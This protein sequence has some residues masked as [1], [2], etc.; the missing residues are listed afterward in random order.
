MTPSSE[1]NTQ[2]R[3]QQ[4]QG[5][6]LEPPADMTAS[7]DKLAVAINHAPPRRS[8]RVSIPVKKA[9]KPPKEVE[10]RG[11]I[12]F[13]HM[14][15][16]LGPNPDLDA[17]PATP[18][19]G[20]FLNSLFVPASY[21]QLR[22]RLSQ[23][24]S[25]SETGLPLKS[26]C[27]QRKNLPSNQAQPSLQPPHI[28]A[29]DSGARKEAS[30]NR[31]RKKL[32]ESLPHVD[33][34]LLDIELVSLTKMGSELG[35]ADWASCQ[36]RNC[37]AI[38]A[39]RPG[40][41]PSSSEATGSAFSKLGSSQEGL[42]LGYLT[43]EGVKDRRHPLFNLDHHLVEAG[44]IKLS[45]QVKLFPPFLPDPCSAP[46][47]FSNPTSC[48]VTEDPESRTNRDQ[49]AV[50]EMERPD[51]EEARPPFLF[52][53]L[54]LDILIGLEALKYGSSPGQDGFVTRENTLGAKMLR[55]FP[56]VL[57]HYGA[58]IEHDLESD[59]YWQNEQTF[60][61]LPR[62]TKKSWLNLDANRVVAGTPKESSKRD[63]ADP[64]QPDVVLSNIDASAKPPLP[65]DSSIE[66]LLEA[67]RPPLGGDELLPSQDTIITPLMRYQARCVAWMM[68]RETE[69]DDEIDLNLP[70]WVPIR[71]K[72]SAFALV[73]DH[74]VGVQRIEDS[75]T[76]SSSKKQKNSHG[77]SLIAQYADTEL[78]TNT[79]DAALRLSDIK[80]YYDMVTGTLTFRKFTCHRREPGG[81]L[82]DS[83]GLGK[84]IESL[85]LI[86]CHP[87][88]SG[89]TAYQDPSR[90]AFMTQGMDENDK[91]FVSHSTLIVCPAALVEQW[92]D[93]CRKHFRSSRHHVMSQAEEQPGI[94][95]FKESTIPWDR[96][97]SRNEIRQ[98]AKELLTEPDI[99]ITTY[100]ELGHQ[101]AL[102]HKSVKRGVKTPLLEVHFWRV[103]LD[104]AQIVASAA[105]QAAEMVSELWRTN[106]WLITGTPITK[107][108]KDISGLFHILDHDPF[109]SPPHFRKMLLEPFEGGYQEGIRR[110]RSVLARYVW[111]HTREHVQHEIDLPE[112][113]T[114]WLE[115]ELP[116]I[117]RVIYDR[118]VKT[119]KTSIAR[120][121]GLGYS[122][123]PN[124]GFL[125]TLRQLLS[126]P[127]IATPLEYG[128]K[129]LTFRQLFNTV[130][131]KAEKELDV[132][133][134]E[135]VS[136]I[137]QLAWGHEFYKT[138]AKAKGRNSWW[139][140]GEPTLKSNE[141]A[142]KLVFARKICERAV[143]E[144][145][146]AVDSTE[147]AQEP[148]ASSSR[149]D[150]P[151]TTNESALASEKNADKDGFDARVA[152]RWAEA[153]YWIDTLLGEK[154]E[155]PEQWDP[156]RPT[157]S[158]YEKEFR[159]ADDPTVDLD[160]PRF[161]IV[162]QDAGSDDEEDVDEPG[163]KKGKKN[164]FENPTLKKSRL[165]GSAKQRK[166]KALQVW[167]YKPRETI[168]STHDKVKSSLATMERKE[169]EVNFMN[170]RRIDELE[171]GVKESGSSAG[172]GAS[173]DDEAVD[174]EGLASS[175]D[176]AI[177]MDAILAPGVLPCFHSFCISCIGTMANAG[178]GKGRCPTCRA[179]FEKSEVT[180]IIHESNRKRDRKDDEGDEVFGDYG[181]KIS[182]L[183]RD[184]RKR[185][186]EDP[187][188]KAV[189]FSHWKRMLSY[190]QSAL[191]QNG[192]RAVAFSGGEEEQSTSL[193][194]IRDDPETKVILVP[195]R[196]SQ[197]AAGLTLTS[198]D[199]AYLLEPA[200]DPAL[201]AQAMGRINRIGQRRSTK[202]IRVR[203]KDT[204]ETAVI[205]LAEKCRRERGGG[206]QQPGVALSGNQG[207][208]FKRKRKR[209]AYLPKRATRKAKD[210]GAGREASQEVLL[211]ICQ[212]AQIFEI[213]IEEE[214]RKSFDE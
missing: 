46:E 39:S 25:L 128:K 176:C 100:E 150:S 76:S 190:V 83:M 135:T 189:V 199:L 207:T 108:V 99:I 65:L 82:C 178:R 186:T 63:E 78:S 157:R 149:R 32:G 59:R 177:C 97:S 52:G 180:E 154:V 121:A 136:S 133:R 89:N 212:L 50:L 188:H 73:R 193:V 107:G 170:S 95:R 111:R 84:S 129:R 34:F 206:S 37:W 165:R 15:M 168:Q 69:L 114:E 181:G 210:T 64:D 183:I 198:C 187:T 105:S 20:L 40:Y 57:E 91:P 197:G 87:R 53:S 120:R 28:V 56:A 195:L 159:R 172:G 191:L 14:D 156:N 80:F 96:D 211:T 106:C 13:F 18:N 179:P 134:L 142:E 66:T 204:I 11:G 33:P 158:F 200:L 140:G 55:L 31:K 110:L 67:C 16:N 109:A 77:R 127:Q 101:L 79:D 86:A 49:L 45:G 113:S 148:R 17:A 42:I 3:L 213:D 61:R 131:A 1:K 202:V 214:K 68:K 162:V 88:P 58:L 62:S 117:E 10:E 173:Q 24:F 74:S 137:L 47:P 209:D 103:M 208:S 30:R 122:D 123:F 60:Y 185:L 152:L 205:E 81:A 141:L 93:E 143:S 72:S 41:H 125:V 12:P 29:V 2:G 194:S 6:R 175:S 167:S 163:G 119:H 174:Q 26:S 144:G 92:L 118:E 184:L 21:G 153:L 54:H 70:H 161:H 102:S 139:K 94:L 35:L 5:T 27:E 104:E 23:W 48:G 36:P 7:S 71:V 75:G 51:T 145:R 203:M 112:C 19:P 155:P 115:L 146:G 8:S 130:C 85:S 124:Q 164:E 201:E 171:S 38:L 132:Q 196:A 138:D 44:W 126:H 116:E 90:S 166:D 98:R 147:E 192:I 9:A 4:Q 160:D 169:H 151:A 182:G 43:T 22:P